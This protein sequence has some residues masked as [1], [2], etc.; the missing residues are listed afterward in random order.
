MKTTERIRETA[1]AAADGAL[2]AA[3]SLVRRG[4]A[5]ARRLA[6]VRRLHLCERQL[7]ALVYALHKSGASDDALVARYLEMVES[8][9]KA[10]A[11]H[12]GAVRTARGRT[13]RCPV[14]GAT[15]D[16]DRTFCPVC[17]EKL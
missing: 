16:P 11:A 8:A 5:G 3:G 4:E 14:C 13:V 15:A 1:A 2:R 9:E 17:G 12:D 7:G 6:L 10:L